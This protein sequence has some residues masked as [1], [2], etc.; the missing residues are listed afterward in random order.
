MSP[1]SIYD[2][3]GQQDPP[4]GTASV[5]TNDNTVPPPLDVL[6]DV[7]DHQ[8]LRVQVIHWNVEKPLDL[9]GMQVHGNDVITASNGEHVRYQ[10][11][12]DRSPRLVLLVHPRIRV[13]G[14]HGS[15]PPGRCRLAGRRKDEE[16][17]EVIVNVVGP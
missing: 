12:C 8:G 9:A 1:I 3:K 15:D 6:F 2:V 10:L 5:R 7:R 16:F 11:G 17:H 4:L 13:T 14:D